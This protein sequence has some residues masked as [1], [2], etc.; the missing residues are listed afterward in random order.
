VRVPDG[1]GGEPIVGDGPYAETK[2][3]EALSRFH[4]PDC[5]ML[6][7]T[8]IGQMGK[9]PQPWSCNANQQSKDQ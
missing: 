9:S 4:S 6:P 7:P 2:T 1:K 3:K 5:W 8:S